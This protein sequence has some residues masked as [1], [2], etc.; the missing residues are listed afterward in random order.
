MNTS[1]VEPPTILQNERY[2]KLLDF[3]IARV[4]ARQS[5]QGWTPWALSAALAA[6]LWLWLEEISTLSQNELLASAGITAGFVFLWHILCKIG[7]LVGYENRSEQAARFQ[8]SNKLL[9]GSRP[10]L[11][12]SLIKFTLAGYWLIRGLHHES[13]IITI[14]TWVTVVVYV[15]THFLILWFSY[16]TIPLTDKKPHS[17]L[18]ALPTEAQQR[19]VGGSVAKTPM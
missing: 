1:Q 14:L 12:F 15:G 18:K 7:D 4:E 19:L 17:K 2:E 10:M 9:A 6:T 8:I 16:L 3:E 11:V 13:S 5:Q